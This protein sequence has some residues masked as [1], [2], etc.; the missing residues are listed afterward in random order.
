MGENKEIVRVT[1][2]KP[3]PEE[4]EFILHGFYDENGE[5]ILELDTNIGKV[6]NRC[7][8][9][10]WTLKEVTYHKDGSWVS[11]V[12]SAPYKAF[13]I[14]QAEPQKRTMTDEQRLAA[15]E[16][17]KKSRERKGKQE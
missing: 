14:R 10:G 12:W 17:L 8:K 11:S 4:R 7:Q 16:R 1:S 13:S 6:N 5:I 9:Q 2:Y 15:A 3:A